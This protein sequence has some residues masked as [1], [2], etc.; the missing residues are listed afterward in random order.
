MGQKTEIV[1]C[2]AAGKMG[3]LIIQLAVAQKDRFIVKAG[4]EYKGH[5]LTGKVNQ[6]GVFISDS[7]E[8]VLKRDMVVIDFSTPEGVMEHLKVSLD[9]KIPFVTGVT[10]FSNAQMS[11]LREASSSISVFYSPNMSIGV[12][13]FF[14]IIKFSAHILR[15]YDVE[16]SEIHHNL[17]K[18][19]PSGTAKKIANIIC[20]IFNREPDR[21]IRYGREGIGVRSTEEIGVH[22][23]R[24]GDIVGEHYVYFGGKGEVI[25]I[26][27]RCYNREAFAAGALRAASYIKDKSTGFY[28]MEDLIK[29]EINV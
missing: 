3:S 6:L 16:I 26:S 18:D 11:L 15:E 5:P 13:L 1:V 10:G 8:N 12:N 9:K 17:K 7:L 2:G 20:Q 19:A 24:L 25:E 22:S 14:E 28:S 4:V 23:L 21:V 27:H 29:E